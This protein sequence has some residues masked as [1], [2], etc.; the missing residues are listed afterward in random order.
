M[1]E[2]GALTL[3]TCLQ[4]QAGSHLLQPLNSVSYQEAETF[5]TRKFKTDWQNRSHGSCPYHDRNNKL[6]RREQ[7][8]IFRR[9]H[10]TSWSKRE[11]KRERERGRDGAHRYST[12]PERL[13]RRDPRTLSSSQPPPRTKASRGLDTRHPTPHQARGVRRRPAKDA[14]LRR[15]HWTDDLTRP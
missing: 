15:L 1:F 2:P 9:P 6:E 10:R 12:V 5:L 13:G 7:T 11:R 14:R 3:E 4:R 8:T